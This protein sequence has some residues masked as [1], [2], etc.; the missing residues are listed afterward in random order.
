MS[1][2]DCDILVL[3]TYCREG[4]RKRYI[5]DHIGKVHQYEKNFE[6]KKNAYECINAIDSLLSTILFIKE[7]SSLVYSKIDDDFL[8][9]EIF[10]T[11][12]LKMSK[13]KFL[14]LVEEKDIEL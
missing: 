4:Y 3:C 10:K 9:E 13:L 12:Q 14:N 5:Q 7:K 2:R 6:R 1:T 11:F 8:K